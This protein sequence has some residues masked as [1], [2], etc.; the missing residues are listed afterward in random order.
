MSVGTRMRWWGSNIQPYLI[1]G[2]DSITINNPYSLFVI[3]V[4]NTSSVSESVSE[5][6]SESESES[7]CDSASASESES[8]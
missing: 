2:V 3:E 4:V 5:S 6:A 8:G 7:E 1:V